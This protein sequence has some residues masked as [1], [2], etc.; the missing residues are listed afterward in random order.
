MLAVI[1]ALVKLYARTRDSLM[2]QVVQL[3]NIQDCHSVASKSAHIK[4]QYIYYMYAY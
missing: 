2:L 3:Y 4:T 1:T